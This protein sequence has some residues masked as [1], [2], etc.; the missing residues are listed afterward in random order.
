MIEVGSK[1][2]LNENHV[3][4]VYLFICYVQSKLHHLLTV[5]WIFMVYKM[6]LTLHRLLT[7]LL[8]TLDDLVFVMLFLLTSKLA[9][10]R[11]SFPHGLSSNDNLTHTYSHMRACTH[12]LQKLE[13]SLKKARGSSAH[14]WSNFYAELL[15]KT[16]SE[17]K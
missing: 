6:Y 12:T 17:R 15:E 16:T 1:G 3:I 7:S 8:G 4:L 5:S 10:G 11:L 14:N 2:I 13:I 9:L